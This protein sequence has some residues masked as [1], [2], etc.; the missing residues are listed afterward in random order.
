M[1]AAE[2]SKSLTDL[3]FGKKLPDSVYVYAD[4]ADCLPARLRDLANELRAKLAISDSFNVIKFSTDFAVSFLEYRDFFTDPHPALA[5]AIRVNLAAGKVKELQYDIRVNPPILH[6]K[7]TLLPL[8]HPDRPKF[9]QLT[10]QEEDAGLFDDP[11]TIGFKANWE[12]LLQE[13]GLGYEGHALVQR[14]ERGSEPIAADEPLRVH[15]H[16]TAMTRTEL[17]KPIRQAMECGILSEGKTVFDYG[18]GLGTD[19]DGLRTLGYEVAAWDPAYF[20]DAPKKAADVVNLGYVLNVIEKPAERIAVLVDAWAHAREAL[21][22]S[23]MISGRESYDYVREHGDGVLTS[24][25]TF[26]KYFE[27]PEIQGLIESALECDAYP[28]GIGIYAVFK[29]PK[30]GQAFLAARTRRHID[31]E[32]LSSRLGFLRPKKR[33][34][35][36]DLYE[37]N[38]D[39]LDE[40]WTFALNLGRIPVAG[41]FA[42]EADLKERVGGPKKVHRLFLD[43]YGPDTFEAARKQRKDDLLVYLAAA[44][45]RKRIPLKNLDDTLQADLLSHFGGYRQAQEE[46]A[47]LLMS[48]GDPSTLADAAAALPFG[49]RDDTESHF[50]IH[51]SLVGKLPA[52]LRVF[53]ECGARLY[54]VATEA[55][56]IKIHLRSRKLTFLLYDN[57]IR[58]PFP[59]LQTRIKIDLPRLAVNIFEYREAGPRQLLLFKERFVDAGFPGRSRMEQ[60][61]RRVEMLGI[62]QAGLGPND[63]NAPSKAEF[64][65]LLER[66]R[67]R[68]DLTKRPTAGQGRA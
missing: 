16:R 17:S 56:V 39:L 13:K 26:Q 25:N 59:E 6:R 38:K 64:D 22:I 23:T 36:V 35:V 24:R 65:A 32:Q 21:I 11:R 31:W 62:R 58:A 57:F 49:W 68:P 4:P 15:R 55:D 29:D 47:R 41:E 5:K 18:C 53:V 43:H 9:A 46:G 7:E 27:P 61:S 37:T 34:G 48:L 66:Y 33:A 40:F 67:L 60:I 45:F 51:S 10:Q 63:Q 8:D 30:A 54:G 42:R 44:G 2:Y 3:G 19:A 28:L 12:S 52:V 50:S 14:G 1:N 20:P